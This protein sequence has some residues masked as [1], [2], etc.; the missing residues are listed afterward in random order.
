MNNDK[1]TPSAVRKTG[2]FLAMVAMGAYLIVT[3]QVEAI[4]GALAALGVLQTAVD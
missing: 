1:W 2:L 3:G 4:G